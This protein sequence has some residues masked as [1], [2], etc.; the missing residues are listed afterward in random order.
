MTYKDSASL[1]WG[2]LGAAHI[3]DDAFLPALNASRFARPV[4]IA[5]RSPER[6]VGARGS[7]RGP[8]RA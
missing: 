8:A 7:A 2:I 3:A 4:A 6:A 1:G 5:S